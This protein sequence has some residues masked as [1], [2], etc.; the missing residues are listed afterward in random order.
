MPVVV[1]M[2]ACSAWPVSIDLVAFRF[3]LAGYSAEE[4]VEQLM[5]PQSKTQTAVPRWRTSSASPSSSRSSDSGRDSHPGSASSLWFV[6]RSVEHRRHRRHQRKSQ[7]LQCSLSVMHNA[8]QQTEDKRLEAEDESPQITMPTTEA[9]L[10]RTSSTGRFESDECIPTT[11]AAP[12]ST[13]VFS[14]STTHV[15]ASSTT[16]GVAASSAVS[17]PISDVHTYRHRHRQHQYRDKLQGGSENKKPHHTASHSRR[18]RTAAPPS[19]VSSESTPLSA[20]FSSSRRLTDYATVSTTAAA[21]GDASSGSGARAGGS[22][23]N[24]HLH[25]VN[26]GDVKASSSSH[27]L[28]EKRRKANPDQQCFFLNEGYIKFQLQLQDVEAIGGSP[29]CSSSLQSRYLFEEVTEQYQTFRELS[30]EEQLGSPYAFLSNY[31]I[32]IPVATRLQLLQ[33]FYET[34]VGIFRWAFGDKLSRF[35]LPAALSAACEE[36]VSGALSAGAVGLSSNS[37]SSS[38]AADGVGSAASFWTSRW[39]SSPSKLATMDAATVKRLSEQHV[40]ALRRQWENVKRV[41]VTVAALYRGRGGMCVP[42]DMPLL[43]TIQQCFGLRNEQAVNYATAAFGFEHHLETRLFEHLHNFSEYGVICTIVASLWCDCSG[44]FLSGVFRDGCRRLGRLLDEYR[45]LSELHFII[46]GE[47]MRP[48]WQV[49]LDEVQRVI[50]TSSHVDK[51]AMASAT[52]AVSGTS[53]VT[54]GISGGG[55]SVATPT[56]VSGGAL[57]IFSSSVAGVGSGHFGGTTG[58]TA[59]DSGNASTFTPSVTPTTSGPPS[60][61]NVHSPFSGNGQYSRPFLM[62]FPSLMKHLFRICVTLGNNGGLNDGLDIFFTRIYSYLE[63]LSSRTASAIASRMVNTAASGG[64]TTTGGAAAPGTG[65]HA[66]ALSGQFGGFTGGGDAVPGIGASVAPSGR[67]PLPPYSGRVRSNDDL[68]RVA[69]DSVGTRV[70]AT[71]STPP[72]QGASS[73][74]TG[75]TRSGTSLG[76][77]LGV[78]LPRVTSSGHLPRQASGRGGGDTDAMSLPTMARAAHLTTA[79]GSNGCVD[80]GFAASTSFPYAISTIINTSLTQPASA[81]LPLTAAITAHNSYTIDSFASSSL[82]P[83]LRTYGFASEDEPTDRNTDAGYGHGEA[84]APPMPGGVHPAS[85]SSPHNS[86]G[87]SFATAQPGPA[88]TSC[89]PSQVSDMVLK[90]IDKRYLREL[91]MLLTALPLAWR[92]LTVL[93]HE[94]HMT[95]DKAVCDVMMALKS[96][97]QVLMASDDFH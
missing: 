39:K 75:L 42:L 83:A 94:D 36:N 16:V 44:Y 6:S 62:E 63:L 24:H 8:Q 49:Q 11:A 33:M 67:P 15:S 88:S 68:S 19:K 74:S 3:F 86:G 95:T 65:V 87:I 23:S 1:S 81:L 25:H 54:S 22:S 91:C 27:Q 53:P 52:A 14:S 82:L 47:A 9:A 57:P 51:N 13:P 80:E 12:S 90:V 96:I 26:F 66:C 50:T 64:F 28:R 21:P 34:D 58:G 78:G 4:A 29:V 79:A 10:P 17:H 31:Y 72:P 41:C 20:G 70:P 85:C 37:G 76:R 61:N 56:T 89:L 59:P 32:P 84:V 18:S 5:V 40:D 71:A 30:R 60:A 77:P 55:G 7:Q 97:T 69:A 35:D 38:G 48:R 73:S 93:T 2:H 46:F 45:I 43:T 92:Q